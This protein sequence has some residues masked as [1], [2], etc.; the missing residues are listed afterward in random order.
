MNKGHSRIACILI[1]GWVDHDLI[2][3]L[4]LGYT[5]REILNVYTVRHKTETASD[6]ETRHSDTVLSINTEKP[7]SI[8][9]KAVCDLCSVFTI[10][11]YVCLGE[12]DFRVY[13]LLFFL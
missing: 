1:Q 7:R 12:G 8:I 11:T 2:S 6:R 5:K 9:T 4:D 10:N 13:F 3:K